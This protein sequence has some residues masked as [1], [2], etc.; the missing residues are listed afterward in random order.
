MAATS[1]AFSFSLTKFVKCIKVFIFEQF[2]CRFLSIC[3][4]FSKWEDHFGSTD[5][6]FVAGYPNIFRHRFQL[7]A[8]SIRLFSSSGLTTKLK[9]INT[10]SGRFCLFFDNKNNFTNSFHF[11]KLMFF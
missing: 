2:R 4:Q 9:I 7:F 11:Q 6:N 5:L 10:F 3:I 8:R 1:S